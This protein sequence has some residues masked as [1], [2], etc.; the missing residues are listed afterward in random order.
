[1]HLFQAHGNEVLMG[2]LGKIHEGRL[3]HSEN[4]IK[5]KSAHHHYD[6]CSNVRG[7][8]YYPE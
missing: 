3:S 5:S 8:V 4:S 7:S 2:K 6:V 1:M